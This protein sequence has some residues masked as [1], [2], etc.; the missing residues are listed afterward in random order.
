MFESE[1]YRPPM[2]YQYII[3]DGQNGEFVF[4]VIQNDKKVGFF[5]S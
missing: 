5:Y 4:F 3:D 1:M 2:E